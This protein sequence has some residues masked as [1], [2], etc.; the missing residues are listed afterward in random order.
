MFIF[1]QTYPPHMIHFLSAQ[2]KL[3]LLYHDKSPHYFEENQLFFWLVRSSG[4]LV[5]LSRATTDTKISQWTIPLFISLMMSITS[6]VSKSNDA[7]FFFSLRLFGLRSVSIRKPSLFVTIVRSCPGAC[8]CGPVIKNM[9]HSMVRF[10]E[11]C[12]L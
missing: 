5:M 7:I 3:M 8:T 6:G 9:F 4:F 2:L 12:R 1:N 11:L 10:W